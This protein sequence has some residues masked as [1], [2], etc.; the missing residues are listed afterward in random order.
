MI[1]CY[2]LLKWLYCVRQIVFCGAICQVMR[3]C[4]TTYIDDTLHIPLPFVSIDQDFFFSWTEISPKSIVAYHFLE[5]PACIKI[6]PDPSE[7]VFHIKYRYS[8]LSVTPLWMF[9]TEDSPTCVFSCFLN[10]TWRFQDNP[11]KKSNRP[12]QTWGVTFISNVSQI[13][14]S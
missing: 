11:Y 6:V 3:I 9:Y 14:S 7:C 13:S 5:V 2:V 1:C 12:K 4:I 10:K 8:S